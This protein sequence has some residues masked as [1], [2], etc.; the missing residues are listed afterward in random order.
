MAKAIET[1][2]KPRGKV[3]SGKDGVPFS[4]D[5]QP[6]PEAKK[7]GWQEL[8]QERHLTK[9]I[10]AMLIGED[11][12]PNDTFKGYLLKLLENAKKGNPKAIDVIS[13]CLEEEVIK[14]DYN[15]KSSPI[16][17][18]DP[19]SDADYNSTT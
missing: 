11:G 3:L 4:K 12:E 9:S 1:T 13:K 7:K 14:V 10:I 5:Y 17:N 15:V 6:T 8:R 2:G 19:I 18:I 16:L